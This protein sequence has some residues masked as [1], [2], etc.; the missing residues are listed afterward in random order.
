MPALAPAFIPPHPLALHPHSVSLPTSSSARKRL[1]CSFNS[2]TPT[3]TPT[4]SPLPPRQS[5]LL[6]QRML[7][8]ALTEE[9]YTLA[10]NLRDATTALT[11]LHDPLHPLRSALHLAVLQQDF[12]LA[13]RLRDRLDLALLHSTAD[14]VKPRYAIGLVVRHRVWGWRMVLFG[15][16]WRETGGVGYFAAVDQRD[17]RRG[18]KGGDNVV[19]VEQ[20]NC[21]PVSWGTEVDHPI[22]TIMFGPAKPKSVCPWYSWYQV[23]TDLIDDEDQDNQ[24]ERLT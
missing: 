4:P 11:R 20:D 16:E 17:L 9:N 3:P 10:A 2:S 24:E 6:L 18:G 23:G 1:V 12:A 13:A 21:V 19:W 22:V 5:Q 14:T 15:V 8:I 7:S